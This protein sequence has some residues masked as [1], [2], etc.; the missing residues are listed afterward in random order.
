[1]LVSHIRDLQEREGVLDFETA[2]IRGA[3]ERL[4]P[5]LMTARVTTQALVPIA[6]SPPASQVRRFRHPWRW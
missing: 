4:V 6:R 1:M 5:I 2:V 3:T